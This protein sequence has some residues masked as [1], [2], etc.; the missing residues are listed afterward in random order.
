[1]SGPIRGR[2]TKTTNYPKKNAA[3]DTSFRTTMPN[4]LLVGLDFAHIQLWRYLPLGGE[5]TNS[6][7][8]TH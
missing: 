2:V 6:K 8:A 5:V 3:V 7:Q 1:M 4:A